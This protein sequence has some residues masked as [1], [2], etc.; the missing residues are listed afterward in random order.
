MIRRPALGAAEASSRIQTDD[1]I[2]GSDTVLE[3]KPG[4]LFMC[5]G[6]VKQTW[7]Q[8]RRCVKL[9]PPAYLHVIL[10][11]RTWCDATVIAPGIRTTAQYRRP[12]IATI[13][14][15]PFGAT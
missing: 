14:I 9:Q 5:G 2:F 12:A 15:Y 10:H 1:H 8:I 3:Q 7:F 13:T 6:R 11:H 4:A